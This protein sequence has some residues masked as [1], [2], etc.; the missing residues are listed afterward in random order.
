MA[1]DKLE[2]KDGILQVKGPT[3]VGSDPHAVEEFKKREERRKRA[4]ERAQAEAT[5]VAGLTP[6]EIAAGKGTSEEKAANTPRARAPVR[7]PGE[8]K[9]EPVV[10]THIAAGRSATNKHGQQV[11]IP[12][13]FGGR[14]AN[15]P[16]AKA[17][18]KLE[19]Q[20]AEQAR[21]KA[22]QALQGRGGPGG[23]VKGKD[24]KGKGKGK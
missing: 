14:K 10:P 8:A 9:V 22:E 12:N 19:A 18:A 23:A 24:G 15:P 7:F 1:R 4:R 20:R 13:A 2:M 21:K 5:R 3:I 6:E 11:A 16:S 17:L